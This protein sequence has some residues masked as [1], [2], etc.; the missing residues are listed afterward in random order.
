M[1][2]GSSNDGPHDYLVR[3]RRPELLAQAIAAIE[4]D[5]CL[6]IVRR[7]GPA[8]EPHTL[9]VFMTEHQVQALMQRFDGQLII[10]RDRSLKLFPGG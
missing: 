1:S 9:V 5:P 4:A 8:H 10:E 3:A 6:A 2:P 7:L